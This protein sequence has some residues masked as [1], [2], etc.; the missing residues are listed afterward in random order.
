MIGHGCAARLEDA[1]EDLGHGEDGRPTVY[2]HSA[3][4]DRAKLATGSAAGFDHQDV[5]SRSCQ[6]CCAHQS[7]DT[8]S[9]YDDGSVRHRIFHFD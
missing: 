8:R 2:G 3:D 7:A 1:L 5:A 6:Q 4:I 9:D